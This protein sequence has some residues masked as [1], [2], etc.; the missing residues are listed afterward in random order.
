MKKVL[1][2]YFVMILL[3]IGSSLLL[4]FIHYLIFGNVKETVSGIIL[5]MAYVPVGIFYNILVVDRFI[6]KKEKLESQ[7][8]MNIIIGSFYHEVGTALLN[9]IVPGDKTI[10]EI[11]DCCLINS[12]WSNESFDIL[13]EM[14]KSYKCTLDIDKIDLEGLRKFLDIQDNFILNLLTNPIMDEYSDVSKMLIA[15]LHLRDEL[16]TRNS[17][18]H[19]K[20]Y[21]KNHITRDIC[22]AYLHLLIQWVE[23]MKIL[24]GYYPS[25]FVKALINSPF[26]RRP[27][28]E[29]DKE[30][31]KL[32][33]E[34]IED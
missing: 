8:K 19:L 27:Q 24:K 3:L 11:D 9:I 33:K 26:D 31:L 18:G 22:K 13:S 23:Y 6:E 15:L 16:V 20:G 30:Y 12:T 14:V 7:K 32:S 1:R 5:S 17:E 21:E 28:W 25:L 2:Q 29:K 34:D 4:Y 10:E